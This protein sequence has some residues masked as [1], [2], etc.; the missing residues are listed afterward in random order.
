MSVPNRI[1]FTYGEVFKAY[2][3]CLKNKKNTANAIEYM[4]NSIVNNIKLT[5]DINSGK[6][7][8]GKSIAFCVTSPKLREVFAADFRDRIVHHLVINELMPL[9]EKLFIKNSYSCRVGKGVL[10]GAK[11]VYNMIKECSE[12]YTKDAWILKM[13][14]KSFF[15][16]IDKG[17]LAGLLDDFISK[18]Y[19]ENRKKK[20]LRELCRLIILHHPE[21]NCEKRGNLSLWDKLPKE[22]SLFTINENLGLPI[23]NLTSQIFAN[24]FLDPLDKYIT[25]EL[26]FK[27]YGRYVDDFVIISDD[28]EKLLNA[29]KLIMS[30]AKLH[31]HL[32]VNPRKNYFQHYK[33]GVKFIGAMLKRNRSYIGNRTKGN[34]Y[35]RLNKFFSEIDA[36]KIDDLITVANSYLGF[37]VHY[38]SYNIRK[39]FFKDGS[40]L[41]KWQKYVMPDKNYKKIIKI[42]KLYKRSVI[43]V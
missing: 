24:F 11:S 5:D 2:N 29:V 9:F 16:T 22:K 37:M 41:N 33:N 38:D 25:R 4:E 42:N 6:Y 10:Y 30:F 17:M 20:T 3:D 13:D 32:I 18:N 26:G 39:S 36:G 1:S 19:P 40:V 8:I 27:Y 31:L 28:K 35:Y 12:N 43:I 7:E 21:L 23:G 15:M 34:L 14:L